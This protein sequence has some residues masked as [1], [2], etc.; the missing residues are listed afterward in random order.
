MSRRHTYVFSD[1]SYSKDFHSNQNQINHFQNNFSFWKRFD[2]IKSLELF[3]LWLTFDL[4]YLFRSKLRPSCPD[5][6]ASHRVLVEAPRLCLFV[7]LSIIPQF[8]MIRQIS[9]MKEFF[10]Y[11]TFSSRYK[12]LYSFCLSFFFSLYLFLLLS[13]LRLLCQSQWPFIFFDTTNASSCKYI[14]LLVQKSTV[15][16]PWQTITIQFIQDT[17]SSWNRSWHVNPFMIK[18]IDI[19]IAIFSRVTSRF[20]LQTLRSI[21]EISR[22]R[23]RDSAVK[24]MSKK[25]RMRYLSMIDRS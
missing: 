18:Q 17:D 16:F 10:E 24:T 1:I 7:F 9:V 4:F 5:T 23:P 3:D 12:F 20:L 11:L 22:T 14:L 2:K 15:V 8:F 25:L 13:T 19:T 21:H 6:D